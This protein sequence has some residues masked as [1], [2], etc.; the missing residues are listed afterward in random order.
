MK[1]R[2]LTL[3]FS[4]CLSFGAF[5]QAVVFKGIPTKK[6]NKETLDAQFE[7]YDIFQ[8]DT[9]PINEYARNA[10]EYVSFKLQLGDK[11]NWDLYLTPHDMRG[12]NY[13]LNVEKGNGIVE[14]MPVPENT[15]YNGIEG[16]N[17]K[18]IATMTASR[19]YF[20]IMVK[21][22]GEFYYVEAAK[23]IDDSYGDDMF[24][25]YKASD[26][27]PLEN[28]KCMALSVD[29][30]MQELHHSHDHDHSGKG[31][32]NNAES[33]ACK[34]VE[35]ALAGDLAM[36]N[37]Y[38]SVGAVTGQ[39][40]T[41]LNNVQTNFDD[42]FA[43]ELK[44]IIVTTFVVTSNN[45]WNASSNPGT[46]LSSFRQ[47]GN[48]GGFGVP[49]DV[50]T[51]W[52]NINFNGGTIGIAY[53][54]GVC[55]SFGY[56]VCEDF[57]GNMNLL[58]V[59]QAHELGHNFSC[60]HDPG[61]SGTIMAPA[62]N[63]TNT[64]SGQSIS[65]VNSYV[66]SGSGA[67]LTACAAAAPPSANFTVTPQNGC[68]PLTVNCTDQSTNNPTFWNYTVTLNGAPIANSTQQNPTFTLTAPGCYDITLI[69]TNSIGSSAPFT[70]SVTVEGT[71]NANFTWVNVG[72]V[73]TF[74]NLTTPNEAC[75]PPI[76][77]LWDFGDGN[78]ST[79]F[80]PTHVYSTENFWNVT[81]VASNPCGTSSFFQEV[82]SFFPPV[83]DF[84]ADAY[85]GCVVTEIQF[86]NL[87][88][89][90]SLSFNWIFQGGVPPAS[91][92]F[93]PLVA[94]PAP[95]TYDV[96]LEVCNPAGCDIIVKQDFIEIFDQPTADAGPTKLID[97]NNQEIDLDGSGSSQGS[98]FTYLWT[99]TD[100]NIVAGANTL[101]PTVDASG[102]YC[103]EVM[104]SNGDNCLSSDCVQVFE[105]LLTPIADAGPTQ[106]IDCA[107]AIAILDGTGSS[108]NGNFSYLW[109]GP[110]IIS[111]ETTLEPEVDQSGIYVL[112]VTNDDNGCTS[113]AET[114]VTDNMVSPIASAGPGMTIDCTNSEVTLD[115]TGSSQGSNYSYSWSG[116]GIVIGGNSMNPLVNM[117]GVYEIL[118]TDLSNGC[119]ETSQTI[120]SDNFTTPTADAG[121]DQ[122]IDCDTPEAELDG[123]ASSQ[124]ANFTYNWSG[125]NVISGGNTTT[126]IVGAS[127]T[128]TI[129]VTNT[130]NGC[131]EF[132]DVEVF[133][134][135][136]D[137]FADAGAS[138]VLDCNTTSVNL[139]GSASSQG[140]N[141]TYNW[142]GPSIVSGQNTLTPEVNGS[143]TYTITVLDTNNG[144]TSTATTEVTGD[145][146]VP[147]ADAGSSQQIDCGSAEVDLDGSGSSQGGGET[148]LWNGPGI[149]SGETT[150]TPVVN[151]AGTYTITVTGSNGC[152]STSD[153]EVTEDLTIPT[154][155]AGDDLA[156]ACS[157]TSVVLDGTNS[158]Q[159]TNFS[160]SWDGPEIISGGNTLEPTV[161]Q[162]G[163][164]TLTVTNDNN[165]CTST[166]NVE[167]T[168]TPPPSTSISAQ[169]NVDCNGNNTGEATVAVSGGLS[170]YAYEWS[171]GG[172]EATETEL[173][174]GTYDVTV[175][176]S[177]QCTSV[178]EVT[179]TE[180]GVLDPNASATN[181]T[182]VGSNDG[183][184]TAEPNGGTM[185]YSYLW[186]NGETTPTIED[187][188]PGD[189]TVTVT[190][191]NNCTSEQTVTVDPYDCSPL[192]IAL[193]GQN[194]LCF[195]SEDGEATATI[196]NGAS[197]ISYEWS[198]GDMNQTA[199]G[200]T[201][202]T[203][204]VTATDDKGCALIDEITITE[205]ALLEA[206]ISSSQNVDCN[207]N[208][209]GSATA[210]AEGGTPGYSYA[211]P[212]GGTN[213]TENDLEAGTYIVSVTDDNG[214]E[215]TT[216]VTITEP[217]P[218]MA[219][220]SS[221][222]E[223]EV[224]AND[225]TATA[226]PEGGTA[227]YTYLWEGGETTQTITGLAPGEYC[228]T[229][230]DANGCI[231]EE[232]ITVN[233]FDCGTITS[234]FTVSDVSC[235]GGNDGETTVSMTGGTAPY[236]YEW[237]NDD[238]GETISDL[239]AGQYTV[240]ATDDNNC[241]IISSVTIPE[242]DPVTI[243]V[244]SVN[245]VDC[246]GDANG[247]AS[248]EASGGNDGFTYEW[249]DGTTGPTI[250]DVQA[251]TYT[252]VAT[253]AKNC[254]SEMEV[255]IGTA[256]DTEAPNVITQDI[257]VVLNMDGEATITPDMIDN[258]T[259]DNCE[260]TSISLDITDLNCDH[261]GETIVTLTG[262][263]ATGN[264]A[265][266]TA[267]VT[268]VDETPPTMTCPDDIVTNNC[269][270]PVIYDVPTGEDVCGVVTVSLIEGLPS[271]SVF[272]SGT[273]TVRWSGTD[274]SG[275]ETTC[276]FDVTVLSDLASDSE[277]T[278]PDCNGN[279]TGTATSLP[280]G[281]TPPY[282]YEWN[283]PNTQN[284]QTAENLFA[285]I[286]SVTVT[287]AVGCQVAATVEV[288]Q[289][290]PVEVTG[291]VTD[292]TN[293]DMN[294]AIDITPTGGTNSG[295]T[296]EW[297]K[298]GDPYA[299][300][301]D[302]ENLSQGEYCVTIIDENN[303]TTEE[304]F[305][306]TMIVNTTNPE[307][308]QLI[309]IQ[310]NPTSGLVNVNFKLNSSRNVQI[311]W[312]DYIGRMLID[313][314]PE[315]VTER[316]FTFDLSDLASGVYLV[317][318]T[319]DE[320]VLVKKVV[321]E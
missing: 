253:D 175:T 100:G 189:Y 69:A 64:W 26:V 202:G 185:D 195:E 320:D 303:C 11:Y 137:P 201:A 104:D 252:V 73:V 168:E 42:E 65:Q 192:T 226:E 171:S 311:Q 279:G 248:V 264:T 212:S 102:E 44:F 132:A 268:V 277:S 128:Y 147:T 271:G 166:S 273:T 38:G 178:S 91:S 77:W 136:T 51:C 138:M 160:Y 159:G 130:V 173:G 250:S 170:P 182:A 94:Y 68:A 90:N 151:A 14:S 256:D 99:T 60:T 6:S 228:V 282:S 1:L 92:D 62:V 121:D 304:C 179:I 275:N 4:L 48:G 211:W 269:A 10:G 254:T 229:V 285:G 239:A 203:Y 316:S 29:G 198:N 167:V 28:A 116:P 150:L 75:L 112:T 83:A 61:G 120:V 139:D 87:A 33:L 214:C 98:N 7:K 280:G 55:N 251:G 247:S 140:A 153:V 287:D 245:D 210:T 176:D 41:V 276:S 131:T 172:T 13:I 96:S 67:C 227:D 144:C 76:T 123:T 295:Y 66:S 124:G 16:T 220:T 156:M 293:D 8:I 187:L 157:A 177:D 298:D 302:L 208:S 135:F 46:Y 45:P 207:G 20:S 297:T 108:Q 307:L 262:E 143:G 110:S 72:T 31:G 191:A 261:I 206:D 301:E 197:P 12:P 217:D 52:T 263:D 22:N 57:T 215:T 266:Q 103:L 309:S 23:Y 296:F 317:R 129:V 95:G 158:S 259:T 163:V 186:D 15:A 107:N 221:T 81:L 209:T 24:V 190:D 27:V 199:T 154:A 19:D 84:D 118:V 300:T 25:A 85:S 148:Y 200:L 246:P 184:A 126:P 243:T 79:E 141:F 321:V 78:T 290:D 133:G 240:T 305:T 219:N 267:T 255:E 292:E 50:A 97:C 258:G 36:Y 213:A 233:S 63:N 274:P 152:T 5:A 289:P 294:G 284:T 218:L 125:P 17:H 180:P 127:G 82:H 222:H 35:I 299:N 241:V 109:T 291:D 111:G 32:S 223:T 146:T 181:L 196:S 74:I 216:E 194:A 310:P 47:W 3:I 40:T 89:N 319:V 88:S 54:S 21:K 53:L 106:Q 155:D 306:V 86:E 234:N 281:G 134:D 242:P 315:A 235:N 43:D 238:T 283:D 80:E 149:V 161:G 205:P 142:T 49:K 231:S 237:S 224:G 174:A 260:L 308:E 101:M 288:T 230:T 164:Y 30:K 165:N 59:L 249:S 37:A 232:C 312:F 122:N 93:A 318:V 105:D 34:E 270:A 265:S 278:E 169:T 117:S 71:P 272:P 115:G 236:A 188:A 145:N 18:D 56:N 162:T 225:G 286:Y 114:E 183:T 70:Q 313:R 39:M 9:E 193:S 244:Q 2:L 257:T 113:E 119:T 58:R 204:T 314:A